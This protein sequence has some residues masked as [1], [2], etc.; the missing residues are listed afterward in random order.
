MVLDEYY[1]VSMS[2]SVNCKPII[3]ALWS[4]DGELTRVGLHSFPVQRGRPLLC[5]WE[6]LN[7]LKCCS[8][9][10][11]WLALK[12]MLLV[13]WEGRIAALWQHSREAEWILHEDCDR[14]CCLA[15]ES[16]SVPAVLFPW[17]INCAS[18]LDVATEEINLTLSSDDEHLI[19]PRFSNNTSSFKGNTRLQLQFSYV[20]FLV[21]Y[22]FL[23]ICLFLRGIL[24]AVPDVTNQFIDSSHG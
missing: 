2:H 16:Q 23:I 18:K 24:R 5:A 3:S 20:N 6:D 4:G 9:Y 11:G 7:I 15:N 10:S 19:M 21:S 17:F 13:M 8:S 12:K 14:F 1:S 22:V